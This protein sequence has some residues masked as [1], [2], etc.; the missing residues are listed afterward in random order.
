MDSLRE[1]GLKR[2]CRQ[3]DRL[4]PP[5]CTACPTLQGRAGAPAG[6]HMDTQPMGT[7]LVVASAPRGLLPSKEVP[8][9]LE[10]AVWPHI[11]E[12]A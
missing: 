10:T 5:S 4:F 7:V 11:V 2:S 6:S 9:M 1:G 3:C 12:G 8:Y